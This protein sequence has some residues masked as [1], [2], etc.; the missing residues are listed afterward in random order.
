MGPDSPPVSSQ[1][2]GKMNVIAL[3]WPVC[4]LVHT[5]F[6]LWSLLNSDWV[7]LG[8]N[9]LRLLR[10]VNAVVQNCLSLV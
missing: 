8:V 5:E 6:R 7:L 9:L 1:V 4:I 10:N 2:E 3:K